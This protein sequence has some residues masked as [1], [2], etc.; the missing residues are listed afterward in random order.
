[1]RRDETPEEGPHP[2]RLRNLIR[3]GPR[4]GIDPDLITIERS[5]VYMFHATIAQRWQLGRVFVLGDAA[6]QM[7]PFLGQ[8]AC[9]GFRDAVNLAWK[10]QMVI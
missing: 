3:K 4:V 6:H 9:A 2:E 7:P 8:G 1:L 10:L 5:A